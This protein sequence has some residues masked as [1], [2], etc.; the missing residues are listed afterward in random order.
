[1]SSSFGPGKASSVSKALQNVSA[2]QGEDAV[3]TCEVTQAS[4]TVNWAKEGKAIR[5]SQKYDISQV[6]KVM[7]LTIHNVSAQDSG[8]Y[9]CEVVGGA[10]T[11]A[12]LEIKGKNVMIYFI[13]HCTFHI[14]LF[15]HSSNCTCK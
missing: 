14:K 7:K 3:F 11:R 1:M 13:S 10:T 9:S 4:S 2:V 8:E 12:R 15:E 6:E 5:K